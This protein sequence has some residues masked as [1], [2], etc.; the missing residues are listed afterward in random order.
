MAFGD[1][2]HSPVS[3]TCAKPADMYLRSVGS[4]AWVHFELKS[5]GTVAVEWVSKETGKDGNPL[6][7]RVP[8]EHTCEYSRKW[9]F[10]AA[11]K[12]YRNL[13]HFLRNQSG[14]WGE[15]CY[16]RTVL[17]T[18]EKYPCF[19][20]ADYLYE[21]RYFRWYFIQNGN[22]LCQVFASDDRDKIYVTED[23]G[24]IEP[25]AWSRMKATGFCQPPKN[26]K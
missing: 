13:K 7:V 23:V 25:W 19:D 24:S 9:P 12:T 11:G 15:D 10:T 22:S 6:T 26:A 20:S 3:N 8:R 4:G 5:Y 2:F 21:H 17:C 1:L 16:G 18:K 14:E